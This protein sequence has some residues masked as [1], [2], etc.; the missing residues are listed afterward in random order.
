MALRKRV[1]RERIALD[2]I[3]RVGTHGAQQTA[4]ILASPLLAADHDKVGPRSAA[5]ENPIEVLM[6][7]VVS[8]M[9]GIHA[10]GGVSAKRSED[11]VVRIGRA[12]FVIGQGPIDGLKVKRRQA[13]IGLAL[14]PV[15]RVLQPSHPQPHVGLAP[16]TVVH[17]LSGAK[18]VCRVIEIGCGSTGGQYVDRVVESQVD[19]VENRLQR[20]FAG[21]TVGN[22]VE[23]NVGVGLVPCGLPR[24]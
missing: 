16:D 22:T 14:A 10:G 23:E 6:D 13:G 24:D 1:H 21:I 4:H 2:G 20:R 15:G 9:L 17:R 19:R 18:V 5:R 11:L 12:S 7:V 3:A 8:T